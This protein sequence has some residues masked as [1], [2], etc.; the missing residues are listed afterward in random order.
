MTS[1]LS[2]IF[3]YLFSSVIVLCLALYL[4]WR[5]IAW[6]ERRGIEERERERAGT[7]PNPECSTRETSESS[8]R[9]ASEER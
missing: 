4:L 3:A 8:Q 1:S 9:S 5:L 2:D 6:V 7:Q